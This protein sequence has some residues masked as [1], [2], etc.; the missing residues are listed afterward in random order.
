MAKEKSFSLTNIFRKK[1]AETNLTVPK[2]GEVTANGEKI[3][4][5]QQLID[6]LGLGDVSGNKLSEVTY[7]SCIKILSESIAKMPFKLLQ[8]DPIKGKINCT[9]HDMYDVVRYR[10]NDFMTSSTFMGTMETNRNHYGNAYAAILGYGTDPKLYPLESQ[11]VQVW[12]DNAGLFDTNKAKLWYVYTH[13]GNGKQ[14]LFATE[15]IIHVRSSMSLDGITGLSIKDILASTV[16]ANQKGQQLLSKAYENGFVAKAVLQYTSDLSDKS[17]K[18]FTEGL[19]RYARGEEKGAEL[20]IPIPLGST[21]QPLNM[22][23]TDGQFLELKQY[24]ALQIA[25]AF[26]IKPNQINDYTKASYAAAE[27]QQLAFY[28]ETLLYILKQYEEEFS[29]KLLTKQERQQGIYFKFNE[30]VILRASPTEQI[31]TLTE[32]I[33]GG[34]YDPDEARDY[35]DLPA[36]GCN[37]LLINGSFIPVEDAGKQYQTGGGD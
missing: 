7:F 5:M 21:I 1:Q 22:K 8:K 15:D 30:A 24:S 23:F 3:V 6:L 28:I 29:Y 37:K 26:G 31:K 9:W 25:A 12:F 35:M 33:A 14:Y 11:Y 10:P 36:K 17:A 13:P 4:T 20:F 18:A 16:E 19:T 27:Q 2:S 34:L 32:A